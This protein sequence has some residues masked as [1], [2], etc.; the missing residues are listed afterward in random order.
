M[1][2]RIRLVA[3]VAGVSGG[4]ASPAAGFFFPGWPGSGVPAPRTLIN[5]NSPPEANPPSAAPPPSGSLPG[6]NFSPPPGSGPWPGGG[7]REAPEPA[8]LTVA[9]AGLTMLG[10]GRAVRRRR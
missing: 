5:P 3:V 4:L 1:R 2:F 9:L 10:L 6:E 8:T 7:P